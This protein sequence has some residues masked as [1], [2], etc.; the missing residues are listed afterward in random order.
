MR[1][2]NLVFFI[3]AKHKRYYIPAVDMQYDWD[4]D[5]WDIS[6]FLPDSGIHLTTESVPPASGPG[7][8]KPHRPHSAPRHE[9]PPVVNRSRPSTT[10][11]R[12]LNA[13]S[14]VDRGHAL[15]PLGQ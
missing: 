6:R 11:G 2:Y 15:R 8:Q 9:R 7:S 13:E 1:V 12:I 14:F 5:D 3:R 10:A 4:L